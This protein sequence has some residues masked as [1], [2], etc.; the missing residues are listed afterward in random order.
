MKEDR[1]TPGCL[2]S[3]LG[4]ASQK[5][6]PSKFSNPNST[7]GQHIVDILVDER[8]AILLVQS[9][10]NS[11]RRSSTVLPPIPGRNLTI[12]LLYSSINDFG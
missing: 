5:K 10:P 3:E 12:R 6:S 1:D 8:Y 2:S 7:F 4:F 9:L 11:R